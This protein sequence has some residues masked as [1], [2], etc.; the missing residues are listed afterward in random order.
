[1][2]LHQMLGGRNKDANSACTLEYIYSYYV[3]CSVL[4]IFMRVACV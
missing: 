1:M 2:L 4:T 3:I